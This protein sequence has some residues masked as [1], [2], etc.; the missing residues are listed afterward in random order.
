M[1][2][3]VLIQIGILVSLLITITTSIP[4]ISNYKPGWQRNPTLVKFHEKYNQK[5][6][7]NGSRIVG[8][9]EVIPHSYPHQVA[10]FIDGFYFC[11]GSLIAEDI[12]ITAAHCMDGAYIARMY[13][14]AHN[15]LRDEDTQVEVASHDFQIHENYDSNTLKND[16]AYIRFPSPVTFNSN[17]QPIPLSVGLDSDPGTNQIVTTIGWGQDSDSSSG[18][19]SVLREVDVPIMSNS[20]CDAVYGNVNDGHICIDSAGG[21]GTCSGDSGGPLIYNGI[22]VGLT[23]FGAAVGCEAGYPDAFTRISNFRDWIF[24]HTGI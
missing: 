19:S 13:L 6:S 24:T 21:K 4:N 14:G 17:I 3:K 18:I 1:I 10:I 16:I 9:D 8:G 23:S 11:G 12:V 7:K 2:I 15:I 5:N 22:Q 20:D